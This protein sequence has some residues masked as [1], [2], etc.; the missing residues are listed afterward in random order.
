M[1]DPSLVAD[2]MVQCELQVWPLDR[3]EAL[4]HRREFRRINAKM[5]L[6]QF[7]EPG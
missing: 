3:I 4:G 1:R 7:G 2:Q 5:L 6:D